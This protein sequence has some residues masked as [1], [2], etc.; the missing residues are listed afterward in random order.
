MKKKPDLSELSVVFSSI[1][2]KVAG[3]D[4]VKLT[5]RGIISHF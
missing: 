3:G 5:G 2:V 1:F 4:M